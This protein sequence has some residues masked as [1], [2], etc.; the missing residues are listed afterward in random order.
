[1]AFPAPLISL[2]E[3]PVP[4]HFRQ[5]RLAGWGICMLLTLAITAIGATMPAESAEPDPPV[6]VRQWDVFELQ[7]IGP[8]TGNPFLDVSLTAT[9]VRDDASITA[10]GFY[11]GAGTYRVR[12]MPPA[13]GAWTYVTASNVGALNGRSGDFVAGPPR[14][15]N[16]GPVRVA[17]QH[18]FAYADGTRF[19]PV[20]TTLYC[21]Q[22]ERYD[23]TLRTLRQARIN[24]IRFMPM[25]HSGNTFPPH[26]P[27]D[28]EPNH[29]DFDRPNPEFWR[30]VEKAVQDLGDIGVQADFVFFH[31]YESG[32]RQTWGLGPERMTPTQRVNY[33]RYAVARLAAY[34]N[35]WW[36]MAN[37]YD[38][39]D[40]STSYWEPLAAAVA[41]TDP[42][43]HL[44]SIHA[45]PDVVYPAWDNGWLTHI[46][47]QSPNVHHIPAWR[48]KHG[49]PVIDDEYQYE[50]NWAPWGNLAGQEASHRAWMATILGG[51]AT[52]GESYSP[53]S[54]FWKGGTPHGESFA[55]VS[56]LSAEV[57]N[58]VAKP[59]PGGLEPAD[60]FSARAGEDYYLFYYG[61]VPTSEKTYTMPDGA[62]FGVDVLDTWKMTVTE[63]KGT[64]SGTFRI[65]WPASAYIAVRIYRVGAR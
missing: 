60:E 62:E 4:I 38:L 59:V 26:N 1:M 51:Y 6:A 14:Q 21:W 37:E 57:L 2:W 10:T 17:D 63:M 41:T 32:K 55:R 34:S 46:S 52:H 53:Y 18:H 29:W 42:Y 39:I 3:R 56:W 35:V 43:R 19:F 50:G 8:S 5:P 7:L 13:Q 20:G 45:L 48:N 22:L 40:A 23:E 24:K 54:F 36:S 12:F 49:K 33:V 28:G 44:Q 16:H 9:F 15:G 47:M 25:P 58:N 64:Y 61:Q 11:D 65:A 31:P 27:W 30:F